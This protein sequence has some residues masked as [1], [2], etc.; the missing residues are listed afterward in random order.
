LGLTFYSR[1]V[2]GVR[3]GEARIAADLRHLGLARQEAVP[4]RIGEY[5]RAPAAS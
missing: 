3:L 1:G 5:A 2:I 4:H